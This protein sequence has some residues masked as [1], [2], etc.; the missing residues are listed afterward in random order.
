MAVGECREDLA[1]EHGEARPLRA[2][3]REACATLD[4]QKKSGLQAAIY[5][6]LFEVCPPGQDFLEQS[7]V[8]LHAIASVVIDITIDFCRTPAK[9]VDDI[10]AFGLRHR[11]A[12]HGCHEVAQGACWRP[13]ERPGGG[14]VSGRGAAE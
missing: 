14:R 2:R 12:G 9:L 4:D 11:S 1:A 13:S 8:Y 7:D 5:A 6:T 3:P 10:S